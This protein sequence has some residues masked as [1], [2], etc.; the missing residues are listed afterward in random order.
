MNIEKLLDSDNINNSIIE[1][2]NY[3]GELCEYGDSLDKLTKAQKIFYYNQ[4]LERE[5]NNGGFNQYFYNSS[6]DYSNETV[7][8]L[9]AIGAI[10]TSSILQ[11]AIN[12]FP[13]GIVPKDRDERISLLQQIENKANEKC[14]KL[15][16]EFYNYEDNLNELNIE[17][18]KKNKKDF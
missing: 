7:E 18:I 4:C 6:G 14:D 9:K 12:Q 10:K 11:R 2:D 8:A 3:V 16:Q 5:V 13:N 1:I 15:D 17:F